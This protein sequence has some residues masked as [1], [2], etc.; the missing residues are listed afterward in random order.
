[1]PLGTI[2]RDCGVK[3]QTA[4]KFF[5]RVEPDELIAKALE[6]EKPTKL[7]GRKAVIADATGRPLSEIVEILPP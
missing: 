5:L 3:H 7:Y 6:L 2:L 1:V 4:A